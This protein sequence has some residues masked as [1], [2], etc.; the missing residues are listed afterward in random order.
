VGPAERPKDEYRNG[1]GGSEGQRDEAVAGSER[2][3]TAANT[4]HQ[5]RS[6]ELA[7]GL[8]VHGQPR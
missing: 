8:S 6:Q 3:A 1:H 5:R 2:H 7:D 4:N